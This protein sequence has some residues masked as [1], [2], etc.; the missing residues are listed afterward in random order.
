MQ[1]N[2][3]DMNQKFMNHIVSMFG[4]TAQ[5]ILDHSAYSKNASELR[6]RFSE[7]NKTIREMYDQMT[8]AEKMV[9][10]VLVLELNYIKT[11]FPSN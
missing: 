7:Y 2:D 9:L 5:Y 11:D 8:S 4:C 3:F 10:D 6:K 1:E